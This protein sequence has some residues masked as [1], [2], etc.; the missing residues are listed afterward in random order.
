MSLTQRLKN[1]EKV[2]VGRVDS[3]EKKVQYTKDEEKQIERIR[4][5]P[6]SVRLFRSNKISLTKKDKT[7]KKH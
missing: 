4:E 5:I 3:E 6:S 2:L 1:F 7:R